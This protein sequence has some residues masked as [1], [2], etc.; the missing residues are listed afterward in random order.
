MNH[1]NFLETMIR[2]L[3]RYVSTQQKVSYNCLLH[4]KSFQYVCE[5]CTILICVKCIKEHAKHVY[6]KIDSFVR[7]GKSTLHLLLESSRV[8]AQS[9]QNS[10]NMELNYTRFIE[11][12]CTEIMQNIRNSF[13]PLITALE[14][15]ECFLLDFVERLHSHRMNVL[16]EQITT[17][18]GAYFG[19]VDTAEML[20]NLGENAPGMDNVAIAMRLVEAQNSINKFSAIFNS[21][22]PQNEL[23]K[24]YS[25]QIPEN[26]LFNINQQGLVALDNGGSYATNVNKFQQPVNITTN[27]NLR[28]KLDEPKRKIKTS[29]SGPMLK[30]STK[31]TLAGKTIA[32]EKSAGA[33]TALSNLKKISSQVC[34]NGASEITAS[35]SSFGYAK[36]PS[37]LKRSLE[38]CV[39]GAGKPVANEISFDVAIIPSNL[40]KSS[41]EVRAIVDGI[42]QAVPG[43]MDKVKTFRCDVPSLAFATKGINDGQ[44][45]RPWGVCVNKSGHIFVTDRCNNNVQAF[46]ADG[47]FLHRFGGKGTADGEFD[48]PM[49]ICADKS[50]RLIVAD[51]NN[52]RI[53][54]FS[55]TGKFLLTFGGL[56]TKAGE[57]KLP[58]D[59][60]VNTNL[61]IAVADS[62]NYRIQQF[63]HNGRF[64]R[65]IYLGT[66]N[67]TGCEII[68]RGIC[69]T[70]KGR[71]IVTDCANHC[72]HL[73]DVGSRKILS[74]K[75]S[76][77]VDNLQFNR[78]SGI[79]SDDQGTIIVADSHNQR[80]KVFNSTLDCLWSLDVRPSVNCLN[81]SHFNETDRTCNVALTRD[82]RIVLVT[83]MSLAKEAI[84]TTKRFVHVY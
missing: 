17:L 64:I 70:P 84:A 75:G 58:F 22:Q 3:D 28:E 27:L 65:Q 18:K 47:R 61:Q 39:T 21:N 50:G 49:G 11:E 81:V 8:G 10:I 74:T 33:A 57:L 82:G 32:N 48:A 2:A 44:V 46:A 43:W 77:G 6:I 78:P 62:S 15:R 55:S 16:Y 1:N 35:E 71:I 66:Y 26:I 63:E 34:A 83:E 56:G 14:D 76:Q 19:L 41:I 23:Y 36:M 59:V 12:N 42:G 79:C 24:F 5:T 20:Q 52:H 38:V 4:N 60:A 13:R 73:V 67:A 72:L 30:K 37:H 45:N 25:P 80:I 68:P 53:Q 54:V 31:Y 51:M 9:F 69:Y 29:K 7:K 40:K